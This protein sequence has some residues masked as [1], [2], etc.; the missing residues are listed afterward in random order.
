MEQEE[1]VTMD[2]GKKTVK[3]LLEEANSQ[4]QTIPVEKAKGY[5][6]EKD[7]I[8]IDLRGLNIVPYMYQIWNEIV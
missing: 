6:S 4:I 5:L 2:K 3:I 7:C 8:F 1:I